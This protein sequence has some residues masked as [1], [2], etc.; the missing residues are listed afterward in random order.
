MVRLVL[1]VWTMDKRILDNLGCLLGNTFLTR[2]YLVPIKVGLFVVW[3]FSKEK[4]VWES[5]KQDTSAT[6]L[7]LETIEGEYGSLRL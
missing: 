6:R 1:F 2:I 7:V 4:V 5:E 3:G